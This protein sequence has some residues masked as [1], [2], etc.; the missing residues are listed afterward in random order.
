MVRWLGNHEEV[1]LAR[2]QEA[3][4]A[5]I[6]RGSDTGSSQTCRAAIDG[7]GVQRVC[8]AL[9]LDSSTTLVVRHAT[10]TDEDLLLEW[11]NNP[12]TRRN[13]FS[14][15]R[16]ASEEHHR[17]FCSRLRNVEGCLMLIVETSN[18]VP[19][20]MVRFDKE[21]DIW[22]IN[23]SVAGPYRGRGLGRRILELALQRL[24]GRQEK[25]P[26]V[27]RV[28]ATNLASHKIFRSL[29]FAALTG[30]DGIVEY[31]RMA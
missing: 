28:A 21:Q 17:W 24:A 1:D 5:E 18:G 10:L 6:Q 8:A 16:I 2:L 25:C 31:R 20:G 9:L 27:G 30:R 13:S 12:T 11:A 26:V 3:L 19:L 29:G 7:K 4:A 15:A 23:Y 22:R 14:K